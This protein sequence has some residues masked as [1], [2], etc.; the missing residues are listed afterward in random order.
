MTDIKKV[1]NGLECCT[2]DEVCRP[3][4]ECPYK[5]T[6]E[7]KKLPGWDCHREELW[8]DALELLKAQIPRVLMLEEVRNGLLEIGW[9]EDFDKCDVIPG[10]RFRLINEG[11]D[12]AVE[13]HVM[14]G[15]IAPKLD[16]YGVRWRC[17]NK[18]PTLKQMY[19]TPWKRQVYRYVDKDTLQSGLAPAT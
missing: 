1:I 12:E 4:E 13:F 18:K 15:F 16:E 14:D 10:I 5:A 9:L 6:E 8:N 11:E 17:W 19:D 3:C 2:V 7:D